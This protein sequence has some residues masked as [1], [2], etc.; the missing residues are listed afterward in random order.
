M[1]TKHIGIFSGIVIPLLSAAGILSFSGC[2]GKSAPPP[3]PPEVAVYTV[4]PRQVELTS[5]LPGRTSA[6]LAAEIRP[7]VSGIIQKRVFTEGSDVEIGQV[8]YQ[9]DPAPFQAALDNALAALGRAE[10][11]VPAVQLRVDRYKQAI[12]DKAVSQQDLDDANAALGQAVAD[13]RYSKAM[14][15]TARINLGYSKIVSPIS[16]RIGKSAVTDGAI[17]TAYQPTA[18]TTIQQLDPIYV[19]VL[20]STTDLLKFQRRIKEGNITRGNNG[21]NEVSL[22]LSDGTTY[23]EKG[24]LQFRDVSVDPTTASVTLRMV[25]PNP[26]GVLLPGMFVRAI[27]KE[28]V[29]PQAILIPHQAVS[30]DA[31]GNP[32]ALVVNR[33]DKVELRPIN[34]DRSMGNEWLIT[35]G[36]APGERVIMEGMQRARPGTPVRAVP[37]TAGDLQAAAA[38][39]GTA[40]TTR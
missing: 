38:G 4:Q 28:G 36:L 39:N 31:K 29:D 13:V 25:F 12:S 5:E 8:L 7:Q 18:L 14:A 22:I 16:G 15:E 11:H 19:D 21:I 30:R 35:D 23:A 20:Q 32:L 6:F 24:T 33:E 27:V 34:I 3:P 2:G 9:I 10:A 1:N 37:F 17:V 26:K 40:P